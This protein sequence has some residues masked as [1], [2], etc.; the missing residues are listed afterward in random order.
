MYWFLLLLAYTQSLKVM[1]MENNMY[2]STEYY[3]S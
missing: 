2:I 3:V 1:K